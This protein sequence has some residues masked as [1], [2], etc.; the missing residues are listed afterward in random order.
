MFAGRFL[1]RVNAMLNFSTSNA[2]SWPTPQGNAVPA[3]AAVA[4][5]QPVQGAARD[6]QAGLG[7][8]QDNAASRH[9]KGEP[10][11]KGMPRPQREPDT[12]GGLA[13]PSTGGAVAEAEARK[14]AQE[15]AEAERRATSRRE[16]HKALQETLTNV[17]QASAAVV[18]RAL[19]LEPASEAPGPRSDTAPDLSAAAA[20]LIPRRPLPPA[21]RQELPAPAPLPLPLAETD[22]SDS[23]AA[24]QAPPSPEE[25]VAYDER[26]NGSVPPPESGSLFDRLV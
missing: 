17:W 11:A 14:V 24:S 23:A 10:G 18:D 25:V 2:V 4:S 19:G 5:V 16:I 6:A 1:L 15:E 9:A 3:V 22:S 7:A 13:G 20:A 8:G 21:A 12:P 26:G